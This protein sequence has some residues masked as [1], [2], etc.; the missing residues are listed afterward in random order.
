[1]SREI[2]RVPMGYEHPTKYNPHWQNHFMWNLQKNGRY[3][4][5]GIPEDHRFIGLFDGT[6]YKE[7]VESWYEEIEKIKRKEGFGWRWAYKFH[8][9]GYDSDHYGKWM[10][11]DPEFVFDERDPDDFVIVKDEEHL[12]EV[13]VEQEL[14]NPPKKE[15]Y[16]TVPESA[17]EVESW[18]YCLYETVSEGTPCSP[19]FAT[20]EEL[21]DYLVN[22]GNFWGERYERRNA[23]ALVSTGYSL[24]SFAVVN[25]QMYNSSLE[26]A[27]LNDVLDKT[28]K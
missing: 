13:L 12:V 5:K 14:R 18:G 15:D 22:V 27:D 25:G 17:E 2:R 1:M 20:P 23:E 9:T 16:T 21:I 6:K 28:K 26:A 11:P 4:N 7:A 19:V 3:I 24:G 8:I 10:E